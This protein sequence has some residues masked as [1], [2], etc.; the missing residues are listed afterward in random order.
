ME[1]KVDI[2][3]K[4]DDLNFH[5]FLILAF[6][7]YLQ[8]KD[9]P[10]TDETLFELEEKG[11]IKVIDDTNFDLRAKSLEFKAE[12]LGENP[13]SSNLDWIDEYRLL[14][15]N[16]T[17][18]TGIM[19]GK[20]QCSKKMLDFIKK[21]KATKDEILGATE[22]YLDSLQDVRYLQQADYFILKNGN[23]RLEA[24]LE[25]YRDSGSNS[26]IKFYDTI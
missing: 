7:E 15:K 16:K 2:N 3:K 19:G 12:E 13:S 11:Y 18:A 6:Y 17:N 23:S 24:F 10:I 25:E 21:N 26:K 20:T 8:I 9:L 14:F 1:I 4:P 5:E 22:L